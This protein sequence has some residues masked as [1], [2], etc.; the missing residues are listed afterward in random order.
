MVF[1]AF[2]DGLTFV[3]ARSMKSIHFSVMMFWFSAIGMVILVFFITCS[4]LYHQTLPRILTYNLDQMY[5][6][7]LT[8]IFSALNLT[9]LTIAYQNDKSATVSLLAYISLVYAFLADTMIF[10]HNF[11]FLELSG[12]LLI[13]TFNLF[14][15]VY[16]MLYVTDSEDEDETASKP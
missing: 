11:V 9:C 13:T 10:N 14:T 1:V 8:G 7:V 3:M 16:K 15:I 6:L 12:A 4:A 2:N 5:N